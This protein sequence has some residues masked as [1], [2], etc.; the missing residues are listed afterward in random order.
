M[1]GTIDSA[2]REKALEQVDAE[3]IYNLLFCVCD[4]FRL[5]VESGKR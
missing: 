4:I 2:L 3:A 1:A 5:D